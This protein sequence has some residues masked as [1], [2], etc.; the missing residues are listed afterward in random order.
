MAN[1]EITEKILN[2]KFK[3]AVFSGY[4]TADVDAFFDFVI[5]Y[6]KNNDKMVELYKGDAEKSRALAKNL[7]AKVISLE[8]DKAKLT[9]EVEEYQAEG[10]GN[11]WLKNRSVKKQGE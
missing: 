5:D 3:K 4:D 1:T 11:A 7:Q 10:Y 6:L 8:K 2:K 9:K